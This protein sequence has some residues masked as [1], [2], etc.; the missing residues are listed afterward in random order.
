MGKP[1][2]KKT[3]QIVSPGDVHIIMVPSPGGPVPTP[4]PHPCTS[5]ITDGVADKVKVMGQPGAVKGSTSKHSPPHVPM[6]PGPFQKPP[7]NKGKIITAS[8]NVF[9]E[10]KPA[11]MLGDTA[12][13]CADP[14][15]AP[16]GKVMGT[17]ATVLIGGGGSG[18]DADGSASGEGQNAAGANTGN[19]AT[20]PLNQATAEG[21]P[22]DVVT[23][24][25]IAQGE[26][27][28]L[29]GPIAVQFVRTYSS[30][31]AGREGTL[32]HG[33]SHNLQQRIELL[34][35]SHPDWARARQELAEEDQSTDQEYLVYH[36]AYGT[37]T[38]YRA[39]A[40]DAE[41]VD[42]FRRRV[43]RR[44]AAGF[45]LVDSFGI[46][47]RF[48]RG[49]EK[50]PRFLPAESSDRN[51]NRVRFWY[52]DA[53][54]PSEIED[55]F[56]R[57]LVLHYRRDR[58]VELRLRV[59]GMS[60][61]RWCSYRYDDKG[62]LVEVLNRA[63]FYVRY[64]YS[65][66]L[67][68]EE[69]DQDHYA[70]YFAYD[71]LRRCVL[72]W[73]QDGY[74]T[75]RLDY[76]PVRR[77]TRVVNGEGETTVYRYNAFNVV[78][79]VERGPDL[80]QETRYDEHG[81]VVSRSSGQGIAATFVYNDA[82]FVESAGDGEGHEHRFVYNDFGQVVEWMDP[83][84]A[85][86]HYEYDARGNLVAHRAATG[87][88]T[89][90]DF[91]DRG[92]IVRQAYPNGRE[93][94]TTYDQFGNISRIAEAGS[95][96]TY[97]FDA[98]GQ[99]TSRQHPDG[100]VFTYEWN[101]QGY[102]VRERENGRVTAE[103][104]YTA[105]GH[106]TSATDASGVVRTYE[107]GPPG[108][109]IV[110][111]EYAAP[112]DGNG[113]GALRSRVVVGVDSEGR[114]RRAT[115]DVGQRYRFAYDLAGRL[116]EQ[117]NPD[118]TTLWFRHD[119]AGFV[120]SVRTSNGDLQR[121]EY[122]GRGM[123]TKIVYA[124]QT[125]D[126]FEY[127]PLG[128]TIAAA[129]GSV[130]LEWEYDAAGQV[131]ARRQGEFELRADA[132]GDPGVLSWASSDGF[133][134]GIVADP[135]GRLARIDFG[136]REIALTME[137]TPGVVNRRALPN[138]IV[139][140]HVHDLQGRRILDEITAPDRLVARRRVAYTPGGRVKSID[141]SLRGG[142]RTFAYDDR[143]RLIAVL[144]VSAERYTFDRSSN[145]VASHRFASAE[146]T[147]S[148]QLTRIDRRTY[149]YDAAGRV[150]R[151]TDGPRSW[152]LRYNAKGEV[153]A[154]DL[155]DGG[156]VRYAYDPLGRRIE[157]HFAGGRRDGKRARFVWNG[158]DVF[159]EEFFDGSEITSERFYLVL[160]DGPC[161]RVDREDG[162]ET[163]V[164]YH[165][166]HLGT[167][168]FCTD[169]DSN[170]VWRFDGD[171]YGFQPTPDGDDFQN[172]RLPGQYFDEETGLHY[173]RFRYYDPASGRYLQPD[174]I[175]S[176]T[177]AN[178]FNYPLDPLGEIDPLGLMALL[179]LNADPGDKTLPVDSYLLS[180]NLP[181]PQ[182]P[183]RTGYVAAG[184]PPGTM[185]HLLDPN[186]SNLG[187]YD[188]I[189]INAH[190]NPSSIAV[191]KPGVW[192]RIR[193]KLPGGRYYSGSM[194]GAELAALL[195]A[196]GFKGKVTLV[197]CSSAGSNGKQPNFAQELADGLGSG[198]EVVAWDEAVIVD[199]HTG[200]A[201]TVW[202]M[203]E[204]VPS[205]DSAMM[206]ATRDQTWG[207]MPETFGRW[208][209]KAGQPPVPG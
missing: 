131:C 45:A 116:S 11:A 147:S 15:D 118:G 140:E 109:P 180:G 138:G 8:S 69:R 193:R 50:S 65:D 61:R 142:P 108:V 76:D 208:T 80:Y 35:N 21:H 54:R 74:L 123:P 132:D 92:R 188:H 43:I 183:N 111:T 192:A 181:N 196:K 141:D 40:P 186:L 205:I 164:Y 198:S 87:A 125:E 16:V 158:G 174:P 175:D 206:K 166:D 83:A 53:G 4:I 1:G 82:G 93:R 9:F 59:P 112:A 145:L 190:G 128:R 39:P 169:D 49:T 48:A 143:N 209:F 113:R 28:T 81:R 121:F 23:G 97:G 88:V 34:D 160:A 103:L 18:A 42:R 126:T 79:R 98:I 151:I 148:D 20:P 38:T 100:T 99:L 30:G 179:V 105:G 64:G 70:F 32:G 204:A 152:Q 107:Y 10:G 172:F 57:T 159:K 176:L 60:E 170:I 33:W 115:N 173:N 144:G 135:G 36:D 153:A 101:E 150:V 184:D 129:N 104:E 47:H 55:P 139:E 41:I 90:Y 46:V 78:S 66:H 27:F 44:D 67:L 134:V 14:S 114:P 3:D 62:D 155:P 189:V 2:A 58:L 96:V 22:V 171:S 119:P 182:F 163:A 85:V 68:V 52:D 207:P 162:R 124:D 73:G 157:K 199:S 94:L 29:D 12:S 17:A 178:R 185:R 201:S 91:D 102:P 24:H 7:A 71:A 194:S 26:D 200:R 137:R 37:P 63:G 31:S 167:P 25:V 110:I 106:V 51:G 120:E 56:G 133:R 5:I 72:T 77:C 187:Q 117:T 156:I 19:Q 149:E 84:G 168:Q 122:N 146:I 13:M 154:V 130:R 136:G 161:A 86:Q 95:I 197:A 177:N 6:G 191:G 127:D 75:R 195:K 203:G 165:N 89:R 202:N